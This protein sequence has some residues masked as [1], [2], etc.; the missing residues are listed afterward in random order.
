MDEEVVKIAVYVFLG[1]AS[2][3]CLEKWRHNRELDRV[4]LA[5]FRKWCAMF[6]DELYE[7]QYRYNT[8]EARSA[9]YSNIPLIQVID[10]W[11][12]LHD[13]LADGMG[14]LAKIRKDEKDQQLCG[15]FKDLM[16]E[17]DTLWHDLET[18]YQFV[19][20]NRAEIISLGP[21][22][23]RDIAHEVLQGGPDLLV[24]KDVKEML[25]CLKKRIP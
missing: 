12:A 10:D 9:G 21:S 5:P 23:Q 14:W 2:A 6:Y 11:R 7:I 19:L 24:N 1:F 4:Y 3:L 15:Q 17:V 22:K 20:R 13:V 18:R 8:K 16:A 25:Q